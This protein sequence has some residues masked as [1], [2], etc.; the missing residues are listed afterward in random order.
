MTAGQ[1]PALAPLSERA[2]QDQVNAAGRAARLAVGALARGE[3]SE[4]LADTRERSARGRDT[5][6]SR[7]SAPVTSDRC[8]SS[9]RATPVGYLRARRPSMRCSARRIPVSRGHPKGAKVCST[10]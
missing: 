3:D 8:S 9:S 6:I 5:P 10:R 4:W 2:W 1:L 7:W